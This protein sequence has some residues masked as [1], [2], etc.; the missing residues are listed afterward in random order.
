MKRIRKRY[1]TDPNVC[2]GCLMTTEQTDESQFCEVGVWDHE[3]R[4]WRTICFPK[5]EFTTRMADFEA[6]LNT[7][8]DNGQ[9]EARAI[10]REALGIEKEWGNTSIARIVK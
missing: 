6:M 5:D 3:I 1:F 8:F 7:A 4:Y 2:I 10:F 9:R